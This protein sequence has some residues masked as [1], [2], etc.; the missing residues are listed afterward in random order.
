MFCM[1]MRSASRQP[2]LLRSVCEQAGEAEGSTPLR[3]CMHFDATSLAH[4]IRSAVKRGLH[5]PRPPVRMQVGQAGGPAGAAAALE[6]APPVS[7]GR[8]RPT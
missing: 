6:D 4:T 2:L 3:R 7:Q 5:V 1:C 8:Q